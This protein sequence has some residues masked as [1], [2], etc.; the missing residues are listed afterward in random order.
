MEEIDNYVHNSL[1]SALLETCEFVKDFEREV[2]EGENVPK[3]K[4]EKWIKTNPFKRLYE[5]KKQINDE[6]QNV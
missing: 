5:D 6:Q 3:H 1:T 2:C 4:F